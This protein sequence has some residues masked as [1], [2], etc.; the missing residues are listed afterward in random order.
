MHTAHALTAMDLLMGG[1]AAATQSVTGAIIGHLW[2]MAV[3]GDDGRGI[4]AIRAFAQ[5]PGFIQAL[6]GTG[7]RIAQMGSSGVHVPAPRQRAG[8]SASAG[9]STG[10]NWGSGNRLGSE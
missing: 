9:R 2:Y 1:P 7:P 10:Y 4:P 5:A 8:D 3:Y 6:V